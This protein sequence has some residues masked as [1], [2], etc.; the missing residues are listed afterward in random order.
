MTRYIDPFVTHAEIF[1]FPSQGTKAV[2]LTLREDGDYFTN[3]V[4]HR[5]DIQKRYA[6]Q[7]FVLQKFCGILQLEW[8][9]AKHL[10]RDQLA[11]VK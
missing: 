1:C 5:G 9:R 3:N 11:G 10:C 8:I 4:I 6:I 2:N 7:M